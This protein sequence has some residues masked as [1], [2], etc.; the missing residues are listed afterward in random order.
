MLA[1]LLCREPQTPTWGI[2][3]ELFFLIGCQKEH[4]GE[5]AKAP[6]GSPSVYVSGRAVRLWRR[7]DGEMGPAAPDGTHTHAT[8]PRAGVGAA[9]PRESRGGHAHPAGARP[10][11][12]PLDAPTLLVGK[13]ASNFP[14]LLG[15]ARPTSS[16]VSGMYFIS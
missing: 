9:G 15:S 5:R 3:C 16:C 7:G 14:A 10:F 1:A 11:C 2:D 12:T 13:T 4:C 8:E 6:A